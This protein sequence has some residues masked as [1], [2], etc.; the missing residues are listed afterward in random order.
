MPNLNYYEFYD[1]YVMLFLQGIS[2]Q[3]MAVKWSRSCLRILAA[4]ET[5]PRT[6]L[7]IRCVFCVRDMH[8]PWQLESS[9]SLR[10]QSLMM[11]WDGSVSRCI[12]QACKYWPWYCRRCQTQSVCN[13]YDPSLKM[14]VDDK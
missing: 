13:M 7:A 1:R 9:N 14:A 5:N 4:M 3:A 8:D 2:P 11:G 6:N 10:H 12:K